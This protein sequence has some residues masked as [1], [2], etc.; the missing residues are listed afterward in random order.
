M[1]FDEDDCFMD[2]EEEMSVAQ[3]TFDTIQRQ[4]DE[5][6]NLLGE[7][8]FKALLLNIDL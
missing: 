4:S 5:L 2:D 7:E 8:A 1:G 6:K 3:R